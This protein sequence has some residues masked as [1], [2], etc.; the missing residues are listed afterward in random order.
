VRAAGGTRS[1]VSRAGLRAR[2]GPRAELRAGRRVRRPAPRRTGVRAW[3]GRGLRARSRPRTR[4]W[5]L[6]RPRSRPCVRVE[7]GGPGVGAATGARRHAWV[8]AGIA[9]LRPGIGQRVPPGARPRISMAASLRRH[10]RIG[11]RT[12][13]LLGPRIS[14]GIG[15]P[16]PSRVGAGITRRQPGIGQ[17]VAPW[18]HPRIGVAATLLRHPWIGL[19]ARPLRHLRIGIGT[20]L[21]RH[22][23]VGVGISPRRHPRVGAGITHLQAGIGRRTRPGVGE[24]TG[25]RVGRGPP[26]VTGTPATIIRGRAPPGSGGFLRTSVSHASPL[27]P[28]ERN[29][30]W[31]SSAKS[32]HHAASTGGTATRSAVTELSAL[33]GA[34][35]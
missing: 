23:R 25:S 28:A 18:P 35:S 31:P 4:S 22:P 2:P 14:T 20:S 33:V 11:V 24:R 34:W 12:S 16:R 10:P 13:A 21:R 19:G 30:S 1:R 5:P 7:P 6:M 17:R 27:R 8:G 32:L 26:A 29:P 9:R 15:A 3:P